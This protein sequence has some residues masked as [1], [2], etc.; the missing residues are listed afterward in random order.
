MKR[1]AK[2][3]WHGS[4]KDGSGHLTTQSEALEK[5]NYSFTSRFTSTAGTNPEELLAAAHA[6]CFTMK[7]S[8]VLDEAGYYPERLETTAYISFENGAITASR[9]FVAGIVKGISLV[10]F[11]ACVLEAKVDCPVSMAL[12]IA[13]TTEASLTD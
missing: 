1:Y 6:G 8:F 13:I 5:N 10:D 12:N 3:V 11:E 2:A 7:L 4:G 9:L